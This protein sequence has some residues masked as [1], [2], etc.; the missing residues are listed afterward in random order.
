MDWVVD[1]VRL[2]TISNAHFTASNVFVGFWDPFASLSDN[3]N[4]SFGLVDNVRV[5]VPAV[6]PILTLQTGAA[7]SLIGSGLT[8]AT[9]I[10]ETS[11]NLA[12]WTPFTSLTATNGAFEFDFAPPDG[13]AQRFFRARAGP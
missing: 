7:F 8:G 10:L 4:L 13:D 1:G 12:D 3:N 11:T 6:A 9:Y 5:E 2:A